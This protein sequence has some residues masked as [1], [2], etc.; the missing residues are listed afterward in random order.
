MEYDLPNRDSKDLNPSNQTTDIFTYVP[1][2]LFLKHWNARVMRAAT[3]AVECKTTKGCAEPSRGF[4]PPSPRVFGQPKFLLSA[5]ARGWQENWK[6]C[7]WVSIFPSATAMP[8]GLGCQES[9]MGR[10]A[11]SQWPGEWLL[12]QFNL[13]MMKWCSRNKPPLGRTPMMPG[14]HGMG[15][16]PI[17][18]ET[19]NL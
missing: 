1:H 9:R 11:F 10:K 12:K 8:L 17:A 19:P 7:L 2:I 3:F 4:E 13:N 14:C 15:Q 6:Q 5:E 18:S 16:P